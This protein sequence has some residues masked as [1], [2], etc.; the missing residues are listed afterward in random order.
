MQSFG[1]STS[2]TSSTTNNIHTQQSNFPIYPAPTNSLPAP[3]NPVPINPLTVPTNSFGVP[4]NSFGVPTNS[5]PVPTNSFGV[6]TNSFPAPTNSFGVPTNSFPAPTNSFG[7]PTNS[8]A[9]PT[10]PVPFSINPVTV[11]NQLAAQNTVP[12]I[13]LLM[14]PDDSQLDSTPF[15]TPFVLDL[16]MDYLNG[17]D[18]YNLLLICNDLLKLLKKKRTLKFCNKLQLRTA[19]AFIRQQ[20]RK[21]K[22]HIV[23]NAPPSYGKSVTGLCVVF[24]R[25]ELGKNRPEGRKL[26]IITCPGKAI[27]TW[28]KEAI[29][30]F[31]KDIFLSKSSDSPLLIPSKVPKLHKID[32]LDEISDKTWAILVSTATKSSIFIHEGLAGLACRCDIIID[33]AHLKGK[34]ILQVYSCFRVKNSCLLLSASPINYTRQREIAK[35]RR[36]EISDESFAGNKPTAIFSFHKT[37]EE[38]RVTYGVGDR[39]ILRIKEYAEIIKQLQREHQDRIAVFYHNDKDK[40]TLKEL[41]KIL[42]ETGIKIYKFTD[43]TRVI[44]TFQKEKTAF[45]LVPSAKSEAINIDCERCVIIRGDW[46]NPERL[47][48]LINRCLRSTNINKYVYVHHVMPRIYPFIKLKC[49]E[50]YFNYNKKIGDNYNMRLIVAGFSTLCLYDKN[51]NRVKDADIIALTNLQNIR[52]E[53]MLEW[54]KKQPSLFADNVKQQMLLPSFFYDN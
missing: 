52:N 45:L 38:E 53:K 3:N 54:W 40:L 31:G 26:W 49:A 9:A 19:Q 21:N 24:D 33:E 15:G 42:T 16:I 27:D 14:I 7:V 44:S 10:N 2:S 50:A 32:N 1:S 29:K 17:K 6:P 13:D 25:W 39:T 34:K 23:F 35:F 5:L 30:L 46:L 51:F 28:Q 41:K 20:F 48:Q 43:S 4:T 8:F 11:N 22:Q 12:T 36:F 37:T 47:Y 18:C